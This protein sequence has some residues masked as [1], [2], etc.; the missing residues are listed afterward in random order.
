[1]ELWKRREGKPPEHLKQRTTGARGPGARGGGAS[2]TVGSGGVGGRGAGSRRRGGP[3]AWAEV[4]WGPRPADTWAR[5][6]EGSANGG[7]ARGAAS[8][9][10]QDSS[11]MPVGITGIIS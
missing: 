9:G 2:A 3:W 6:V 7:G 5:E 8:P 10:F 1:V 4:V 11:T